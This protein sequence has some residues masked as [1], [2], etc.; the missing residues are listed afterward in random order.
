V[1]GVEGFIGG[2]ILEEGVRFLQGIDRA[3]GSVSCRGGTPRWRLR[4]ALTRG[5]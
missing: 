3:A 5:P 2:Q 4:K 1:E